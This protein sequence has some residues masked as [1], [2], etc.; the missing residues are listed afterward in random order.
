[1]IEANKMRQQECGWFQKTTV[2][3]VTN[4]TSQIHRLGENGERNRWWL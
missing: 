1:V 2:Y 3:Y 4:E